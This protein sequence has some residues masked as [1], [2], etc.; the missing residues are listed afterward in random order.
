MW[1]RRPDLQELFGPLAGDVTEKKALAQAAV[2]EYNFDSAC[3]VMKLCPL[4][5]LRLDMWCVWLGLSTSE[6]LVPGGESDTGGPVAAVQQEWHRWRTHLCGAPA[7][8]VFAPMVE[9]TVRRRLYEYTR[10]NVSILDV[11]D[12]I[13]AHVRYSDA[14]H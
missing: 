8:N 4:D 2:V 10:T 3:L 9:R 11:W 5:R 13:A 6:Q 1:L 7:S 12:L 14:S